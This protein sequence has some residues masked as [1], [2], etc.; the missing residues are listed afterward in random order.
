MPPPAVDLLLAGWGPGWL[1]S[2]PEPDFDLLV[3]TGARLRSDLGPVPEPEETGIIDGAISPAPT[4]E[5]VL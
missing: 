4:L 3:P 2:L 5:P 1:L